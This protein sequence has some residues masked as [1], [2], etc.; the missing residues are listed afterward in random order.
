MDGRGRLARTLK[1]ARSLRAAGRAARPRARRSGAKAQEHRDSCDSAPAGVA[2]QTLPCA[3]LRRLVRIDLQAR[4]G[5]EAGVVSLVSGDLFGGANRRSTNERRPSLAVHDRY[6][7]VGWDRDEIAS[8]C[9][10][11]FAFVSDTRLSQ[12]L[13]VGDHPKY[14]TGWCGCPANPIDAGFSLGNHWRRRR[15]PSSYLLG[16]CDRRADDE[17]KN[18]TH[19]DRPHTCLPSENAHTYCANELS[20][21]ADDASQ[22]GINHLGAG[23][24][25]RARVSDRSGIRPAFTNGLLKL[26]KTE[27]HGPTRL[28]WRGASLCGRVT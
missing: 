19:N 5:G 3:A 1:P 15:R 26:S 12:R 10:G 20:K 2:R 24:R 9:G 6:V 25:Q 28:D 18:A 21:H 17:H 16:A 14:I 23:Q 8:S 22:D 4:T 27:R 11:I 7:P 13:T